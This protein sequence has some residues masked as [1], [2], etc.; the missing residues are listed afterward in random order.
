MVPSFVGILAHLVGI[1]GLKQFGKR[2]NLHLSMTEMTRFV[3]DSFVNEVT[4]RFDLF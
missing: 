3:L 1:D 2:G 4:L